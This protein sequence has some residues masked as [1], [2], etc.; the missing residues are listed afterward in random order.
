MLCFCVFCTTCA[1]F[2][3]ANKRA[4][5]AL[6][7]A[8]KLFLDERKIR[9][10]STRCTSLLPVLRFNQFFS[11]NSTLL[12]VL[13]PFFF[14]C[15]CLLHSEPRPALC[16]SR[17]II[18]IW[19]CADRRTLYAGGLVEPGKSFAS[20]LVHPDACRANAYKQIENY[21]AL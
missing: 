8:I 14:C 16:I 13:S 11:Q 2:L 10:K 3:F 12:K 21:S 5:S 7:D 17:C 9:T 18:C 6:R 20:I 4:Q 19:H 15:C 1:P